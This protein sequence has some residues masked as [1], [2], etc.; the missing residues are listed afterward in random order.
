MIDPRAD[1]RHAS[2]WADSDD[3]AK[4]A[5][6]TIQINGTLD[7]GALY[8]GGISFVQLGLLDGG[9]CLVDNV[10]ARPGTNGDN[11]VSNPN[12]D[13][14][15]ANWSLLGDHSRSSLETNLGYPSGGPCLHLRTAD[16]VEVG[17]NGTQVSLT[18]TLSNG[19]V[20]TL[21]FK[22]RWLRGSPEILM[23]VRGNYLELTGRLPVPAN[24]GTPGLPNSRAVTNAGP[25]IYQVS[26]SPA[27][28]AANQPVV[29]TARVVDPNGIASFTLQYRLDPSLTLTGVAM[30]DAGTNGD[31]VAGDGIYSATIPGRTAGLAAVYT[32]L[33][34][35]KR[36]YLNDRQ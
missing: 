34:A 4:S 19:A 2:N 8:D 27:V 23:R 35:V 17:P 36:D 18:N 31:A 21:R 32:L 33:A 24:L 25:A 29:V 12:F 14:G 1:K 7:D 30:N 11:Y 10:E 3:T 28:P 22:A 26:H 13:S 6:T 20:A 9:E 15:L 16:E 5:W